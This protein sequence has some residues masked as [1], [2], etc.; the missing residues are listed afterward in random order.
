M[1]A[2]E[3]DRFHDS[4]ARL[5]SGAAVELRA[6]LANR[7][8]VRRTRP[9]PHVVA[10]DVFTPGTYATLESG[11][12][13]LLAT[14]DAFRRDMTGYDAYGFNFRP[15]VAAPF[16]LFF[17]RAWHDAVA[18]AVGVSATGAMSGGLHHHEPG[19]PD[20][21]IH[22]DLNPAW[23]AAE[24]DPGGTVVADRE[25]CDYGTGTPRQTGVEPRS[26]VRA[27]AVVYY[28]ANPPWSPGDGGETGLYET[29]DA[30]GRP[31]VRVPPRNNSLVAFECTPWSFHGFL[32]NRAERNSVIQWLHRPMSYVDATWSARH[33][34]GWG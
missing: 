21:A 34:V 6:V 9:F 25:L 27:V 26:L 14:P 33:V 3:V 19:G 1:A 5:A 17:R 13:E 20:G 8:W 18:R 11:F 7:R 32:G 10:T 22:N 23:F 30:V 31:A 2:P 4:R 15:P 24:P 12:R 29:R 28:L 16:D